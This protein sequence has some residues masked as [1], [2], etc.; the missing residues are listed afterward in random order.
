[1][2]LWRGC[3]DSAC[4]LKALV[5]KFWNWEFNINQRK[6]ARHESSS[7]QYISLWCHHSDSQNLETILRGLVPRQIYVQP[8][9]SWGWHRRQ[10]ITKNEWH[11]N[12]GMRTRN[13]RWYEKVDNVY[14]DVHRTVQ[15][16]RMVHNL[17]VWTLILNIA[18]LF[19]KEPSSLF[20]PVFELSWVYPFNFL[21]FLE[22]Q[23][24]AN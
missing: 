14:I 4:H 2:I 24:H 10:E 20:H 11:S 18:Q 7:P 19:A 17:E 22:W 21:G 1:M 12:I 3:Y 15:D 8:Y 5:N 9:M 23:E 6:L 13:D 16:Q